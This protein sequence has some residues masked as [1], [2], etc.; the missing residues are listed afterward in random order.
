MTKSCLAKSEKK[1]EKLVLKLF[2]N[3]EPIKNYRVP[4]QYCFLPFWTIKTTLLSRV[5]IKCH[6]K[7]LSS[8]SEQLFKKCICKKLHLSLFKKKKEHTFRLHR[9]LLEKKKQAKFKNKKS[10]E[11]KWQPGGS[12]VGTKHAQEKPLIKGEVVFSSPFK[13]NLLKMSLK[14]FSNLLSS[15]FLCQWMRRI[16]LFFVCTQIVEFFLLVVLWF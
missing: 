15:F 11:P 5:K 14:T 4:K 1:P 13:E 2:T 3:V 9:R 10:K 8:D 7:M 6:P 16:V 12:E